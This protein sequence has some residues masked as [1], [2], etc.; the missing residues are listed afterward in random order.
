MPTVSAGMVFNTRPRPGCSSPK[1]FWMDAHGLSIL[2]IC[3]SRDSKKVDRRWSQTSFELDHTLVRGFNALIRGSADRSREYPYQ[4]AKSA[5][6]F[7]F[8]FKLLG[9]FNR[10]RFCQ[11]PWLIDVAASPHRNM[12]GH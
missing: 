1:K 7:I 10:Y 9:L 2:T 4:S 3:G 8:A 6:H 12:I 5:Y 11:V